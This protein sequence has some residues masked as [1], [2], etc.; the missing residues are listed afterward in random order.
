MSPILGAIL[1]CGQGLMKPNLGG[2]R[3]RRAEG[4]LGTARRPGVVLPLASN[5]P[6][7]NGQH[8]MLTRAIDR[9]GLADTEGHGTWPNSVRRDVK[10]G[11]V[12]LSLSIGRKACDGLGIVLMSW[13]CAAGPRGKTFTSQNLPEPGKLYRAAFPMLTNDH[14]LPLELKLCLSVPLARAVLD[15]HPAALRVV[16]GWDAAARVASLSNGGYPLYQERER[17][18]ERRRMK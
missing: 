13:K 3:Y 5:R 10:R 11:R 17:K 1:G 4:E 6:P 18:R 7:A 12:P 2:I 16:C 15:L 9:T 8:G 14:P